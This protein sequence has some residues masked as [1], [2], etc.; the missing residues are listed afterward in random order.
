[1]CNSFIVSNF[2]CPCCGANYIG[3]TE[4]TLYERKVEHAWTDNN[5]AVYKHFD[6]CTGVQ[7]LLVIASLYSSLLTS[8][9]PIQNSEKFELKTADI[10]LVQN[11]TKIIDR[12]KNR[13]ILLFK[14]VLK[15]DP[16]LNSG[17]KVS[18]KLKLF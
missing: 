7:H 14:E 16:I 5:S 13:N 12:H 3:K 15:I 11:N 4:R 9:S 8:S 2:S 17:L 1:M 10:N 18:K 6:D